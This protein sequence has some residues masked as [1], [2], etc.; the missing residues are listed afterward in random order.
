M[1]EQFEYESKG[2]EVFFV[3]GAVI[4]ALERFAYDSVDVALHHQHCLDGLR[5]AQLRDH[6]H[7]RARP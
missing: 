1:I 2:C 3:D 5:G 4:V 6:R 7:D